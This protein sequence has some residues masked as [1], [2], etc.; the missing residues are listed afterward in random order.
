[1]NLNWSEFRIHNRTFNPFL[2]FMADYSIILLIR[3]GILSG[4]NSYQSLVR[5]TFGLPGFLIL[6]ALQFLYPFIG[7]LILL[8]SFSLWY[9]RCVSG[10]RFIQ[11]PPSFPSAMISY[12][13]TFGDTLTKV[14]QRIPG[15]MF[16]FFY[17]KWMFNQTLSDFVCVMCVCS[18]S[19]SL[20]SRASL[21]YHTNNGGF[22]TAS[23]TLSKHR[24]TREGKTDR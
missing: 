21:C 23:L 12:N 4:T 14:F 3:G 16:Y 22:H 5:S 6:S 19:Q 11:S 1:M 24:E 20:T 15:G 9:L 17:H 7:K 13:I 2:C 10:N 18:W 8:M